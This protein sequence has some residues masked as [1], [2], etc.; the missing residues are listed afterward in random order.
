MGRRL[1]GQVPPAH[2]EILPLLVAQ[3][4]EACAEVVETRRDVV[5]TH[6]EE[7]EPP[8]LL[9]R[10]R[11]SCERRREKAQG[12]DDEESEDAV[13]HGRLLKFM[14]VWG[15]STRDVLGKEIK[16]CR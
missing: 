12:E 6:V 10:L 8:D 16:F 7:P 5:K 11:V 15:H 9:W 3:R 2:V 4:L 1:I 14:D 13:R